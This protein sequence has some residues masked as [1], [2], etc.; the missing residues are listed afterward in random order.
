MSG[1]KGKTGVYKRTRKHI[2]VCKNNLGIYAQKGNEPWNKGTKGISPSNKTSFKKGQFK[3]EKHPAW[4]GDT[5]G[6]WAIHDW[7]KRYYG[8][9][10]KCSYGHKKNVKRFVWANKTG[11]YKRDISD[12]HQLCNRCNIIDGI[13]VNK[14]FKAY[15]IRSSSEILKNYGPITI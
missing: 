14:R 2:A 8:K 5:A 1:T 12:W 3:G 11:N 4:K 13:K 9:A 15:H 10:T 6:Y 7:L